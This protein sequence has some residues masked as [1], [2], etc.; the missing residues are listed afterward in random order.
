M[1]ATVHHQGASPSAQR[2]GSPVNT[3]RIAVAGAGLIG[4]RHIE[5]VVSGR[6]ATL[7][8]IVDVSPKAVDVARRAGVPLF[9]SLAELFVRAKPDGIIV[10]TPN[11]LHV[12]QGL[13]CI[14]AG[15]PVLIEKP[16]A[17]TLA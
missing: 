16:V 6:S 14:A 8:G 11:Q 13:E 17:H 9:A 3:V 2:E 7:S 5:A 1:F 4:P 12:E 15:V 10:A